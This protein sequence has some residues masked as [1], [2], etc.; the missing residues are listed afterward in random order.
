MTKTKPKERPIILSE[1]SVQAIIAGN[2]TQYRVPINPQPHVN[3]RG[4]TEWSSG[5]G[6]RLSD[7]CSQTSPFDEYFKGLVRKCPQ[8]CP[9]GKIGD[10]LW[11][12]EKHRPIGW[13]FDSAMVTIEYADGERESLECYPENLYPLDY[14]DLCD[15]YLQ[16]ITDIL[17][18]KNCAMVPNDYD[19]RF[20]EMFDPYG[21]QR[22]MPWRSSTQMPR[23]ASRLTLEI[24]D[25]RV[26]RVQDV[27]HND[28]V[29]E[30]CFEWLPEVPL[31]AFAQHW[32]ARHGDQS[33]K[34]NPWVWVI[35]FKITEGEV[36]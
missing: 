33:W 21:I 32:K 7:Q 27:T 1:G 14:E 34:Q 20:D 23:W 4:R 24:V 29:A 3:E 13:D 15:E 6:I 2:K 8:I 31:T 5:N 22:L 16:K 35:S 26:E 30:A 28:A 12:R 10:R 25:V 11:V 17:E 9:L 19:W 36:A 18:S